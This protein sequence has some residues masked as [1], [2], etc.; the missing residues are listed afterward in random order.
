MHINL[1]SLNA[2]RQPFFVLKMAQIVLNIILIIGLH[3]PAEALAQ[4]AQIIIDFVQLLFVNKSGCDLL[5]V[6][7]DLGR[8]RKHARLRGVDESEVAAQLRYL[9]PLRGFLKDVLRAANL[10]RKVKCHRVCFCERLSL[11][12]YV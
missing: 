12:F 1:R 7:L 10:F 5:R 9:T 4:L 8:D 3:V 2:R 6:L 11:R